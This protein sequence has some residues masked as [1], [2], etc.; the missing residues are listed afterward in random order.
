MEG[1]LSI[2]LD[3]VRFAV[4]TQI[5]WPLSR[6]RFAVSAMSVSIM[7]RTFNAAVAGLIFAVG[8]VGSVVAGPL[9]DGAAAAGHGDFTT[10]QGDAALNTISGSCTLTATASRTTTW[11]R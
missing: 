1:L 8:F 3:V 4:T 10:D 9:G 5:G 11:L 6:K 7:N 2:L